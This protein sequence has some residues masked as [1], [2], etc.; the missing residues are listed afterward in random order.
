MEAYFADP[1]SARPGQ[2]IAKKRDRDARQNNRYDRLLH[3]VAGLVAAGNAAV[4]RP[5][6]S[7]GM[8]VLL[9]C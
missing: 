5:L 8:L 2:G 1:R 7:P 6:Q 3:S 4:S 9:T